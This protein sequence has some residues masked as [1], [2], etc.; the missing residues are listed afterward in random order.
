MKC[1]IDNHLYCPAHSGGGACICH[2]KKVNNRKDLCSKISGKKTGNWF[3]IGSS[4]L[5]GTKFFNYVLKPVDCTT[6]YADEYQR[7]LVVTAYP[8][9]VCY[10]WDK[11]TDMEG[12]EQHVL[13]YAYKEKFDKYQGG[14]N[15]ELNAKERKKNK[16]G[17]VYVRFY[18]GKDVK[19]Q[20]K[21]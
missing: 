2:F 13:D 5:S 16:S 6:K 17:S 1:L 18:L 21:K 14:L 15:D 20:L 12:S 4:G 3:Y 7:K 9:D 8:L 19:N 10:Y 11:I